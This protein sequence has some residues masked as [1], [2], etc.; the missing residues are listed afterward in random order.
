MT[1]IA[2]ENANIFD[3]EEVNAP[4]TIK[5]CASPGTV[6]SADSAEAANTDV[7]VDGTGCTLLPAFIDCHIDAAA[8]NTALQI[9]ASFGIATVI[10]MVSRIP[11]PGS[12]S[13]PPPVSGS[14]SSACIFHASACQKH[15]CYSR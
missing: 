1:I 5:F 13:H 8:V 15:Y 10:D 12:T 6:M 2:V 11:P 3:S 9:F 7:I 14:S 4:S